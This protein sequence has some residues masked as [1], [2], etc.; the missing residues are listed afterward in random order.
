MSASLKW[1][2]CSSFENGP[3]KTD[4]T[5]YAASG[6]TRSDGIP[7]ERADSQLTSASTCA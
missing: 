5:H 6:E 4:T 2:T 7:Q 3:L 1:R